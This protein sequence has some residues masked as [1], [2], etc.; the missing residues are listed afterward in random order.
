MVAAG[1]VWGRSA[2]VLS[3]LDL[4]KGWSSGWVSQR[5]VRESSMQ[6]EE[7]TLLLAPLRHVRAPRRRCLA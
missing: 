2:V 4:S 5:T 1:A 7:V 6:L 3:S